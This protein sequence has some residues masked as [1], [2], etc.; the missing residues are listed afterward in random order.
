MRVQLDGEFFQSA[1][2]IDVFLLGPFMIYVAKT[3]N[4]M[5]DWAR[6]V[7]AVS[8]ALTIGFNLRNYAL[9]AGM[10]KEDGRCCDALRRLS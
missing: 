7:L 10:A 6:G 1:R 5:P 8:G 3:A 9:V 4:E 2:L